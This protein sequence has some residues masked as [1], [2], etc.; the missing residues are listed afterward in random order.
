MTPDSIDTGCELIS[1]C[2]HSS[3]YKMEISLQVKP[4]SWLYYEEWTDDTWNALET[5]SDSVVVYYNYYPLITETHT[6]SIHKVLLDSTAFSAQFR[7]RPCVNVLIAT[8]SKWLD[9]Q[10]GGLHKHYFIV[11]I[12]IIFISHYFLPRGL[13]WFS[14]NFSFITFFLKV[15]NGRMVEKVGLAYRNLKCEDAQSLR[16]TV[17]GRES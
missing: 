5:V 4:L 6:K 7:A 2:L 1:L 8:L 13:K 14:W 9:I 17:P 15:I 10:G 16:F 12:N 3:I 11:V